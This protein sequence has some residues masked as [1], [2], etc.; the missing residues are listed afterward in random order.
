MEKRR[1]ERRKSIVGVVVSDKMTGTVKVSVETPISHP[2]YKKVVIQ[3]RTFM[4]HNPGLELVNGDAVKISE[5]RPR[6]KSVKWQVVEKL[7]DTK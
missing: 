5:S 1:I 6:A 4:A 2:V 3:K 7:E